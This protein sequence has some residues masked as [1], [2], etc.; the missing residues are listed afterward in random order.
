MDWVMLP[1]YTQAEETIQEGGVETTVVSKRLFL[2]PIDNEDNVEVIHGDKNCRYIK[3]IIKEPFLPPKGCIDFYCAGTGS[4]KT[5]YLLGPGLEN[6]EKEGYNML[7]LTHRK[8]ILEQSA[9]K[10][11][12]NRNL[13]MY[14]ENGIYSFGNVTITS[15]QKL[16]I[17][18]EKMRKD[19]SYYRKKQLFNREYR[20]ICCDEIHMALEDSP[21]SQAANDILD[22]LFDFFGREASYIFMSATMENTDRIIYDKACVKLK[23]H[24][25]MVRPWYSQSAYFPASILPNFRKYVIKKDYSNYY[26][27]YMKDADEIEELYESLPE[28]R[29]MI[30]FVSSKEEGKAFEDHLEDSAFIFA[31]TETEKLSPSAREELDRIN[32]EEKFNCKALICTKVIDAGV[33][34]NDDAVLDIV[35][36]CEDGKNEFI[37][38]VGRKREKGTVQINLY[39][40]QRSKKYFLTRLFRCN[41]KLRILAELRHCSKC[42]QRYGNLNCERC[43][44]N[45]FKKYFSDSS[46]LKLIEGLFKIEG[47]KII[48][49]EM[50]EKKLK[51]IADYYDDIIKEFDNVGDEAF[52]LKQ[53]SWLGIESQYNDNNYF[54]SE[55]IPLQMEDLIELLNENIN[56]TMIRQAE[57]DFFKEKFQEIAVK[58]KL[59]SKR[60]ENLIGLHKMNEILENSD[61]G[62]S[63]ETEVFKEG[64]AWRVIRCTRKNI[65]ERHDAE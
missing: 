48:V 37:Q 55:N 35:I 21:F 64:T 33:N 23:S 25:Q 39:I 9:N 56:I 4:G 47:D 19:S 63:I 60:S 32:S 13:P 46:K 7:L 20:L 17:E 42:K 10:L 61:I 52:I 34:I 8:S 50:S 11:S 6:A 59:Y 15:Y 49:N 62:Y 3:D 5:S 12:K 57:K 31:E 54:L 2:D 45:A 40:M 27:R 41:E 30:V 44:K 14:L 36:A 16:I 22:Y 24:F 65:K 28:G 53:L 1:E 38:I 51:I 29:K 43:L 18:F 58:L 26:V